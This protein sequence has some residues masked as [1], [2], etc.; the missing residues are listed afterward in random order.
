MS[1]TTRPR[2]NNSASAAPGESRGGVIGSI[3]IRLDRQE[4]EG[5]ED[6]GQ[7]GRR[8]RMQIGFVE[9]GETRDAKQPQRTDHLVLEQFQHPHYSGL[10][11][12]GERPALQPADA[13]EISAGYNRLDDVGAA[14]DRAIDHD[15]G[16]AGD[17]VDAFRQYMHRTAAMVELASTVVRHVDPIHAVIE[18]DQ[19]IF[20]GRNA[21]DDQRDLVLVLDQFHGAPFQSLLEIASG[22]AGAAGAD[23]ALG[24]VALPPAVMR[25]VDG[26]TQ[27]GISPSSPPPDMVL[28]KPL[29]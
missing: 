3:A 25:G 21:L 27:R 18:R 15:L 17:G 28:A 8:R 16:A 5:A 10:A 2:S 6:M 14:A 24:D 1:S 26:E 22:G 23:I 29:L 20:R 13:D 7:V 12:G 9:F 19:R 11:L 4:R